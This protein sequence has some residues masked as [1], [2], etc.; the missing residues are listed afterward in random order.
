MLKKIS[1]YVALFLLIL[2]IAFAGL[3]YFCQEQIIQR[4]VTE[5]NR[6]VDTPIAVR[7]IS[8]SVTEQ[9]PRIAITFDQVRIAGSLA[10]AEKPLAVAEQL[11]FTFNLWQL[12]RGN[13]V[14]DR[15]FLHD[16][17]IYLHVAPDGDNYAIFRTPE[18]ASQDTTR[19]R[20]DLKQIVLSKAH[21]IYEDDAAQQKH[22]FQTERMNASLQVEGKVYDIRLAGELL[23]EGIRVGEETYF[24]EK[25]LTLNATLRY[26]HALRYLTIAPSVLH[27]GQGVFQ[28]QGTVDQSDGNAVDLAVDGQHTD[29][30]TLLSLLPKASVRQL[31][32]YRSQGE[33]YFN[34]KLQGR[35]S[36][37]A[38]P[39]VQLN[40]GCHQASFYHPDYQKRLQNA[41]L[42]GSFT[43]GAQKNLATSELILKD[44]EATLDGKP[45]QGNLSIRNFH[46]YLLKGQVKA[47]LDINSWLAFY[48]LPQVQAASGVVL[49]DFSV[50]GS[51]RD[52]QDVHA[53]RQKRVKSVGDITLRDV[54]LQLEGISLPFHAWNGNFIFKNND[55]A[56]SN[57][58]GYVGNSHFL[59][60]GV[61]TNA[62]AYVLTN[63]QYI[64]IEAN[65]RSKLMDVDELLSGNL[66]TA[67]TAGRTPSLQ[68]DWQT[69]AVQQPYQFG[70]DPRLL[71]NFSCDIEKLKFR[72]LK[73]RNIRGKLF[74]NN[75]VARVENL[76]LQA[77]GG[78]ITTQGTINAQ[79]LNNIVVQSEATLE[80][81]AV[82]S[83][84]YVFEEFGQDFL[85][86]RH[87]KGH[88]YADVN[89][90][91]QFDK[92]L[93][94]DYPSLRVEALT[95]FKEGQ[96][97]NFEPMQRLARFIEAED[98]RYLRFAE[99][100][101]RI[102]V[103]DQTVFVPRM[104]VRSNVS[105]LF[106]EGTHTFSHHIDYR[107]EVPARSFSLRTAAARE[108]AARRE[109]AF[110]KV[111]EEDAQPTM[112]F[113]KAIGTVDDYK[114]SYDM[115]AARHQF[116]ENLKEEKKELKETFKHKGKP[117]QAVELEEEYF[118][119]DKKDPA[120]PDH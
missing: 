93:H 70:I 2:T 63:H 94:L 65:L 16:A 90:N 108:R 62:L 95:T 40:F 104:T 11:N 92:A 106:I 58:G 81:L 113:L 68:S 13:Y 88:A 47:E 71:L 72:R 110:G 112:L 117:Q 43:N 14:I 54:H 118:D 80:H 76:S 103:A 33:V 10:G 41:S 69:T 98:L 79:A 120:K 89:W 105:D 26:D 66:S 46:Q 23:S 28:V 50:E 96:L 42:T 20:F 19:L 34:G 64:N 60:N 6:Y 37:K 49:A 51:L 44:I 21:V 74:V 73:S 35:I 86:S 116:K 9:F 87:L 85:T 24:R 75:Q 1:R 8:L 32:A 67:M 59:L 22:Q 12:L 18:P 101:N 17:Q 53:Y 39:A 25:Q 5:A 102:R 100:S 115:N 84:F 91:M 99:M 4:F 52:L 114:I 57:L 55:V 30:Q 61:F 38:S 7:K 119:F 77:A 97:N 109:Q 27:I 82:D 48:P 111:A 45:V 15:V 56:L 36:D 31:S 78:Q 3:V 83:I 107:F 29:L